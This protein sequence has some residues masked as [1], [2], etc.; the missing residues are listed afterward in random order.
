MCIVLYKFQLWPGSN[1]K[2][3]PKISALETERERERESRQAMASHICTGILQ[4]KADVAHDLATAWMTDQYAG[5]RAE[6]PV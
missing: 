2:C 1:Q 6:A 4:E 3:L 5:R